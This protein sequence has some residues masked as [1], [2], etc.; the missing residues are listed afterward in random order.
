MKKLAYEL[1]NEG[2]RLPHLGWAE[3]G[4]GWRPLAGLGRAWALHWA[5]RL[6]CCVPGCRIIRRSWL[7]LLLAE[8]G[9]GEEKRK[10]EKDK[11]RERLVRKKEK[12]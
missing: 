4:M 5:A 7:D 2:T 11:R 10:K 3:F 9:K 1:E 6:V 8:W 12:I